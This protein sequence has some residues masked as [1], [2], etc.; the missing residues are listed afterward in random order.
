[1]DQNSLSADSQSSGTR[2]E[3]SV[4]EHLRLKGVAGLGHSVNNKTTITRLSFSEVVNK[5]QKK[6]L[7]L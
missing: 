1:M 2:N 5:W 6:I 7:K 3:T 4:S